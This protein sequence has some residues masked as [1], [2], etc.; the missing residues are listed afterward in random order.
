MSSNH[1]LWQECFIVF[2]TKRIIVRPRRAASCRL[3]RPTLSVNPPCVGWAQW[4]LF[5]PFCL[6]SMAHKQLQQTKREKKKDTLSPPLFFDLTLLHF[7]PCFCSHVAV[8]SYPQ[9]LWDCFELS[10]GGR[11]AVW[12]SGCFFAADRNWP[13]GARFL[14][15]QREQCRGVT[16][17]HWP[18]L[19]HMEKC[20]QNSAPR[21]GGIRPRKT[22][23]RE[24]DVR[25][26]KRGEET[27]ATKS[28]CSHGDPGYDSWS[29][30]A[31]GRRGCG[32]KSRI[33]TASHIVRL[34]VKTGHE[35]CQVN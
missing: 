14:S 5:A 30:L 8:A 28:I 15:S 6:F 1:F 12:E 34:G 7:P 9:T 24:T 23:E 21:L 18:S 33:Q 26:G 31:S 20:S 17:L 13:H 2:A 32:L 16:P 4:D 25:E 10:G 3:H 27:Y 29:W 22:G 19:F 11:K 35:V